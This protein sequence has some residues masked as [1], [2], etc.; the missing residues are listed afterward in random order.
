MAENLG[1]YAVNIPK[2]FQSPGEALQAATAQEERFGEK[3]IEMSRQQ[4]LLDQ[5]QREQNFGNLLK[6]TQFENYDTPDVELNK[7]TERELNN[8]REE[9]KQLISRDPLEFDSWLSTR[10]KDFNSWYR[11]A[12]SDLGN[13]TAQRQEFNKDFPNVNL[14][15]ANN[16]VSKS[17]LD[18]Y[19]EIDTTTGQRAIKPVHLITPQNDYYGQLKTP[20]ALGEITEYT[21]PATDLFQKIK[22]ENVGDKE[23][24]NK[25]GQITTKK[26]SG[27]LTPFTKMDEDEKGNPIAVTKYESMNVVN[28][29]TGKMEEMKLA[30]PEMVQYVMQS[31]PG[32]TAAMFKLWSDEKKAKGLTNLDPAVEDPLFKNF[33]YKY[34][35]KNLP[36][37]IKTEEG[38]VTPKISVNVGAPAG[39]AGI[40]DIYSEISNLANSKKL[41]KGS[42]SKGSIVTNASPVNEL[43]ATAQGIVL[44]YV[45]KLKG[46]ESV[47]QDEIVI[48]KDADGSLGVY[49][50]DQ[51]ANR[52]GG[53]IAPLDK[54]SIN[55]KAQPTAKGK[56]SVIAQGNQNP[57]KDEPSA[58][59]EEI[60]KF[61]A[62]GD[63][64]PNV[65][66]YLVSVKG[67]PDQIY[68]YDDL[69]DSDWTDADIKKLKSLN[70]EEVKRFRI[71]ENK[72]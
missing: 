10:P 8:I 50:F 46:V 60:K 53:L 30:T 28:P 35:D 51:T 20:Q 58:T 25:R 27:L 54:T 41:N 34:A 3:R 9:G 6:A 68:D 39:T 2:M 18:N 64:T 52:I 48:A 11:M 12:K 63:K 55:I 13:V 1:S 38:T 66:V 67:M 72:K 15:K 44:D 7:I 29:V 36:H 32:A 33:V 17:F 14:A 31:S 71:A 4:R 19:T 16:M 23:Y 62:G 47:G 5:K 37:Q 22:T 43:S 57:K 61:R 49:D 70:T 24:T 59:S 65:K 40:N 69:V 21:Q 45:K 56:S 42:T 26:W